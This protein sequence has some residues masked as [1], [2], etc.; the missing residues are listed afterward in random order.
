LA[1]TAKTW[2]EELVARVERNPLAVLRL[3]IS[4][5]SALR[6]SRRGVGEFTTAFPH[7]DFSQLKAPTLCL[8]LAEVDDEHCAYLGLIG[9]RSAITTLHSR[10]K[11]KRAVHVKPAEPP[12]LIELLTTPAH[13]TTLTKR[14]PQGRGLAVLSPKLS[15][16]LVT[17]RRLKTMPVQCAL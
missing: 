9:A 4:E 6:E 3:D 5:W 17:W 14:L 8:L 13:R 1:E 12:A 11:V 7:A 10:V 2:S 16:E 15:S